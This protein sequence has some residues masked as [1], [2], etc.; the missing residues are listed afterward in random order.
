MALE[1]VMKELYADSKCTKLVT[2]IFLMNLCSIHGINYKFVDELFAFLCHHLLPKPNCLATNYY[3]TRALTQKLGLNYE[4]IH[5]CANRCILFQGDHKDDVN[6]PKCGNV[7]YKDVINKV[8]PMKVLSHFPII[9]R[10]QCLF[11]TPT[12]SE[13]M[14][15]HSQNS[16]V[17]GLMR[18]PCD[19]K[20]WKHIHQ[21]FLDF[22]A[23]PYNV[24]LDFDANGVNPFK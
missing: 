18:H 4:N 15:W 12:M 19:S 11:K 1:D 20:A 2:T 16:I 9:P 8:L 13:L 10:L 22:V 5:G 7:Q 17:N 23:D 3:A 6:C 21:K 24:H 14:L